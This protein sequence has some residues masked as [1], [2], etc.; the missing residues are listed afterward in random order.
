MTPWNATV[1]WFSI[2]LELDEDNYVCEEESENV[3]EWVWNEL[4]PWGV[5]IEWW[6]TKFENFRF[7]GFFG[8]LTI[9]TAS[10]SVQMVKF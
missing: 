10:F 6:E 4:K 2:S 1:S 7:F 3:M 9:K 5:F 8:A